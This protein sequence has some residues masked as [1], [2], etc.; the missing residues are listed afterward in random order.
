MDPEKLMQAEIDGLHKFF[1]LQATVSTTS[2]C[3]FDEN[4]VMR[5]FEHVEEILKEFYALRLTFYEKRKAYL[6]GIL[7]AESLKLSNQARFILEKCSG[8][9]VIENKKKK[10]M[11]E[12]L[13][14]RGYEED[15]VRQWKMKQDK[16]AAL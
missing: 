9:L 14:K 4:V 6:E 1:K 8:E 16:E 7:N 2:M 3:V 10:V 5:K 15:P 13:R 12:E 11:I